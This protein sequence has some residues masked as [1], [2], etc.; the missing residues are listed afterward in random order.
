MPDAPSFPRLPT[1]IQGAGGIIT[2]HARTTRVKAEDKE[3]WGSWD[4]STR[5]IELDTRGEPSHQWRVLYHELM[6]ATLA[7]SGL[8][9]LFPE[10]TVE[11]LCDAVATARMRERFG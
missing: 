9:N 8:E 5:V 11:A 7:D 4:E 10:A 1:R 3:V 6:H 2:V